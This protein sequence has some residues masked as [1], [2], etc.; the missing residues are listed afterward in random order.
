L[1][2]RQHSAWDTVQRG[3]AIANGVYFAACNRA[4]F[5]AVERSVLNPKLKTLK[6][7]MQN[8]GIEFWGQSFISDPMG[9]IVAR[10]PTAG[11]AI[12]YAEIQPS[13]IEDTRRIWPFFRDRRMDLYGGL[14]TLAGGECTK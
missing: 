7:E 2:A 12:I 4:G 14:R 8:E 5:E 13:E 9:E 1:G 6:P 3:H 10:A 11:E